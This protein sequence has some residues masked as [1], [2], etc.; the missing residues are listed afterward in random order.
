MITHCLKGIDTNFE[1]YGTFFSVIYTRPKGC[2]TKKKSQ[3]FVK[4]IIGEIQDE[5]SKLLFCTFP[6]CL[7]ARSVS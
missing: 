2:E 3:K 5:G 6:K 1:V 7:E 4:Q